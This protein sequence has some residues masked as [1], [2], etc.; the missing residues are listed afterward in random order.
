[1]YQQKLRELEHCT[2]SELNIRKK[3][4]LNSD[5]VAEDA[6]KETQKQAAVTA[7]RLSDAAGS[8]NP[9]TTPIRI[10]GKLKMVLEEE[11]QQP[12]PDNTSAMS[13]PTSSAPSLA[14]AGYSLLGEGKLIETETSSQKESE[15]NVQLVYDSDCAS[16]IPI[17]SSMSPTYTLRGPLHTQISCI[18][19]SMKRQDL[20][21]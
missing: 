15:S 1:M 20:R 12:S 14:P 16:E 19:T 8:G 2:I 13:T 5:A 4:H 10:S 21:S 6:A 9:P 18:S 17:F 3:F 11:A 7:R